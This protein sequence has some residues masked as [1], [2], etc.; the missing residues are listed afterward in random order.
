MVP[1]NEFGPRF[2]Q[3]A[4]TCTFA[5]T[6]SVRKTHGDWKE[7]LDRNEKTV[8]EHKLKKQTFLKYIEQTHPDRALELGANCSGYICCNRVWRPQG[9]KV[10]ASIPQDNLICKGRKAPHMS[11]KLCQHQSCNYVRFHYEITK[12]MHTDE[13]R[14]RFRL[15]L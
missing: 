1:S 12:T 15:F 2:W 13:I 6:I 4:A 10:W 9:R 11:Y 8:C 7:H 5:T 14:G 3:K